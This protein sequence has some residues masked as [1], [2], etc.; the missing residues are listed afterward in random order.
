MAPG[1]FIH[2]R[3]YDG[4][5]PNTVSLHQNDQVMI[6]NSSYGNGC[7]ADIPLLRSRLMTRLI[8]IQLLY[9]FF[10]AEIVEVPIA[11]MV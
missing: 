11:V 1:S 7:N 3:Q 9:R 5:L 4:S 2:V 10:H 6:F 8:A